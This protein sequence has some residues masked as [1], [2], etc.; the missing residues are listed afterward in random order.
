VFVS[1]EYSQP[2]SCTE[3]LLN[4]AVRSVLGRADIQAREPLPRAWCCRGLA[5]DMPR[6]T[7]EDCIIQ[8]I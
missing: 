8:Y 7:A 3:L 6:P 4:Q 1:S 5:L 2:F